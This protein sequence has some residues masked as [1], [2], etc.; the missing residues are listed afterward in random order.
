MGN[1]MGNAR[2][3]VLKSLAEQDPNNSFSRYGARHEYK[4]TGNLE[5]A[6]AE[7]RNFARAIPTMRR[8]TTMR[9]GSREALGVW[10][11]RANSTSAA[12][13]ITHMQI[14]LCS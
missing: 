11:R 7:F 14:S 12:L 6:V 13:K 4:N 3:Q 1:D 2:L 8:L 5:Q 9:A 10:T